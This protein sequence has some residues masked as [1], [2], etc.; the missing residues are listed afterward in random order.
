M[1][2]LTQALAALSEKEVFALPEA[3]VAPKLA[4]LRNA[5]IAPR[6]AEL[7]VE[8]Y[9]LDCRIFAER[10][11]E[12][13]KRLLS[14]VLNII[15]KPR[16]DDT[17]EI[18][19]VLYKKSPVL[20]YAWRQG[21]VQIGSD[22]PDDRDE[23]SGRDIAAERSYGELLRQFSRLA[24]GISIFF[25]RN[26]PEAAAPYPDKRGHIHVF[27]NRYPP[28]EAAPN[29]YVSRAFGFRLDGDFGLEHLS[30][31]PTR[32]RGV[33]L[34]DEKG[35]ELVQVLG[36]DFYFLIPLM[37]TF[38]AK[39][40][41]QIFSRLLALAWD[42]YRERSK[43]P[44]R[45]QRSISAGEFRREVIVW[46]ERLPAKIRT[47]IAG[48]EKEIRRYQEA[49]AITYRNKLE[50][51]AVLALLTPASYAKEIRKRLPADFWLIKKLPQVA[52]V[53]IVHEGLHVETVPI[54]IE[55]AGKRYDLGSFVVRVN[56]KGMVTVWSEAPTHPNGIPHPHISKDG[57]AC[58][59]N[60]TDA[61]TKHAAQF[62]FYDCV[63]LVLR[64]LTQGY[65]PALALW[66]I[67]EWPEAAPQEKGEN[68][69]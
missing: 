64:W 16:K 32:G 7:S 49:L 36:A 44:M 10:R 23:D 33:V 66:K 15:G 67:E 11:G 29:R 68:N 62:R 40:S 9:K 17:V 13:M 4:E 14:R 55:H 52:R 5:G 34:K 48:Y 63:S 47:D 19:P 35:T 20:L 69:G 65:T 57:V 45:P 38:N 26:T 27:T 1:D 3:I 60:A 28:G 25:H 61:I 41:E 6:K 51:E 18:H 24:G 31:C 22:K 8:P 50:F 54:E 59:G 53:G 43:R 46:L 37:S 12:T 2:V 56:A 39:T 30:P 42:E 21:E 58:F